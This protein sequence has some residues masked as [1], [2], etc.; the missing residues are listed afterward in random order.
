[1]RISFLGK[2]GSGKTTISGAFIKYLR[3]K[4]KKILAID[5]DINVNLGDQIGLEKKYLGDSFKELSKYLEPGDK[6]VFKKIFGSEKIVI[7][8]TPACFESRFIKSDLN[9]EFF[10][11]YATGNDNIRLLS[12]GSYNE[13]QLGSQCF[14]GKLSSVILIYNR[15]LDDKN[16]YVVTDATAGTDSVGT[17]MFVVSDINL[18]VVEPT[19]KSIEVFNEFNRITQKFNVKNYLIANK[20]GNDRD[21]EFLENNICDK[22]L[23]LG[24]INTSDSIKRYEQ[25]EKEALEEFVKENEE[26]FAVIDTKLQSMDRDWKLY[27]DRQNEIYVNN[28][29]SWYSSRYGTD[30][31]K[32]ID[33]NFDYEKVI[34]NV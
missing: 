4:N 27:K 17:N 14:H 24:K 7:G 32:Y 5:A 29:N 22:N 30:L 16:L 3:N 15:L 1:M 34:N 18:F 11:K 20:I 25:G 28:C 12:V 19:K 23:I 2:G 10:Q 31:T 9:D 33:E 21:I 13:D 8:S 6:G 26:L